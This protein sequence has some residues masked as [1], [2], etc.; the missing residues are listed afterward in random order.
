MFLLS[1]HSPVEAVSEPSRQCPVRHSGSQSFCVRVAPMQPE[2]M[3]CT[4]TREGQVFTR[5]GQV[6][7]REGQVFTCS[8]RPL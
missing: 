1:R 7:T 3:S 8:V 2:A 6:F 5:E 4:F